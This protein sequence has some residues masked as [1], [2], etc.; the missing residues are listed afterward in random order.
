MRRVVT[1]IAVLAAASAL[2]APAA[3]ADFGFLPGSEG[4]S[5]RAIA[6][7]GK[8]ASLAGS[9]PYR[10]ALGLGFK[11]VPSF[12]GQSGPF[13]DGDLRD[14]SLVLP[15]GLLLNPKALDKCKLTDFNT[16]RES[17]FEASL[18]GESCP[19]RT[20]VGTIEVRSRFGGGQQRRFGL[21][22]LAP[23]PGVA[24]QLGAAPFGVPIAFAVRIH[25]NP[26]NSYS[27]SLELSDFSQALDVSGIDLSLWGVPWG[28]SHNGE[29]GNCLNEAEPDFPWAKCS[30]GDPLKDSGNTPLA[31]LTLPTSCLGPLTFTATARA[32]QPGNPV[33]ATTQNANGGGPPLAQ[34]GC[35]S[36]S[37]EPTVEG[38]LTN[39]KA[40]SSSGFNFRL[41][42][43]N[44]ELTDPSRQLPAQTRTATVALASGV[45]LNPSVGA[46][47]LACTPAQFAAE[48]AFSAQGGACPNGAK[49]GEFRLRS[50][51]FEELID[52]AIY[53]AQPDDPTTPAGGA[54]NPFDALIGIYLVARSPERG[55]LVKVAGRL[56][57]D[58][59]T[60]TLTAIF[61]DL[62]QLPYTDLNIDFR[63]GQRAP[64][65]TPPACGA[66]TTG[67]DLVAWSGP[68]VKHSTTPSQISSG[69]GGGPCPA[70]GA[71][72]F[73]PDAIAGGVNANVGSYT[74]YFVHLT[75]T[76]AEQEITSYSLTL[77]KG[78]TG[79]I[80]G[81]P[82]CPDSAIEAARRAR[83][84]A[85]AAN[86]SCPQA[87][88]IGHTNSGYGV[89]DALTYASGRIFLAGP[90]HGSPLSLVTVNSA[91]VGP[92]DLG[93]IVVRSAFD[94][95]PR[96]AQLQIDSSASDPIPHI[97]GGVVLHL[98]DVRISIDRFQFTHNP[99]SCEPSALVSTLT[100]SGASFA[101]SADDST[102]AVSKRFQLLNCLT[103]GFRPK[104]GI[105]LRGPSRR[106]GYPSLR[107]SF[108]SRGAQDSNLKRIEVVMPHSQFL[109]QEHI[110]AICSRRLFEAEQCPAGSVYGHAVAHTPL[111]DTPLR[112]N[113]YL[114]SSPHRLPDLVADLRSGSIRIVVEG[115]IGPGEKGGIRAFFD[116]L[117]D[118]PIE[119][120]TMTLAGGRQG[121][122]QNSADI[123]RFPP[124][125]SVKG[126]A[127]NN[128][129]A[130]FS[131]KLR[132]QCKKK[133][134]AKKRDRAARR[135]MR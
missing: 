113:V 2:T 81:I 105:R 56:V 102:V 63:T 100:G 17:P 46:G 131:T 90:Y 74:P 79:K 120:F 101:G 135:Q 24:A 110:R 99:S 5:A 55:I 82:F 14:L 107:A 11:T 44:P 93:T 25:A 29:R 49:L 39:T 34:Q 65:I 83:G 119:R 37:F 22:N 1:L 117:P 109:A 51:L 30:V 20:Q 68:G 134:A 85:E 7:G 36:F 9:H 94:I 103:L 33:T 43:D 4:F 19:E 104:L 35:Q 3:Q 118:A 27:L 13:P 18:S 88:L 26:D 61:R 78:I 50:P 89:G 76:D 62:P 16:P 95:D 42:D 96:T 124:E 75:R 106:G 80:A 28:A 128:I 40:S 58:P 92:F 47:L 108:V 86:P 72:P 64:L 129:G 111:F 41:L 57:P 52:G 69:V 31:Y 98:R 48:T 54:E 45:T 71:P 126:L 73:A 132:G 127:Q 70:P 6:D 15:E 130:I 114:R 125:A 38:F 87:S 60:G 133:S 8:P 123:C 84:F 77:P 91:T 112:G 115:R 121:L 23:P 32:W 66:A 116:D 122:L 59:T 53:L 67:I 21:F 12:N 97:L 10:L